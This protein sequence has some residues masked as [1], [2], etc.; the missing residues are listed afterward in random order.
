LEKVVIAGLGLIGGSIGMALKRRGWRVAFVDPAVSAEDAHRHAAADD[1]LDDVRGELMVIATP[2]DVAL[3]MKVEGGVVT[4]TCSVMSPFRHYVAGHPF[5]GSEKN[6]LAA[7]RADLFE[8]RPWF[9]SRDD[10]RVREMI[11]ATGAQPVIIDVEEHD[12][13]MALTSHLPQVISTALAS[14][15]AQKKIDPKFIGTGLRTLLRLAGS[16]HDVWGPVLE[17]NERNVAEAAEELMRVIRELDAD[18]F[19]RA[20]RAFGGPPEQ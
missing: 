5:A 1:K 8:G 17:A 15:I 7:G 3:R 12:R 18:D 20:R 16:S 19:A 11:D 6:G 2:V 10:P 14:L 4:T 13:A 9:I